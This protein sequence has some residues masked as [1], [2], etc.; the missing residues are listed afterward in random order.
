MHGSDA[1]SVLANA[2]KFNGDLWLARI[3]STYVNRTLTIQL[4]DPGES[5]GTIQAQV[6]DNHGTAMPFSWGANPCTG[7]ATCS[8]GG[9]T[10]TS[11]T[12]SGSNQPQPGINRYGDQ[13]FNDR[14][15][16]FT[17]T[18]PSTYTA[19]YAATNN[20]WWKLSYNMNGSTSINDR[21]TWQVSVSGSPIHLING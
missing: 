3:D 17:V 2:D 9:A 5:S 19:A 14:M 7:L 18:I 13:K 10:V 1:M 21:T 20:G 4:W 8:S 15:L 6:L 12:V 16:T 11:L